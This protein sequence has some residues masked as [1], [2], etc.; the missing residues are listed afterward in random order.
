MT[1]GHLEDAV[2][3]F[4]DAMAFCKAGY[5]PEYAYT[6]Y[7]CARALLLKTSSGDRKGAAHLLAEALSI[8]EELGIVASSRP[9][10]NGCL[11]WDGS[12]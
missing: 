2:G 7:E 8:S 12:E 11:S 4:H 3:H 10:K 5:R 6:G 1:A 9:R